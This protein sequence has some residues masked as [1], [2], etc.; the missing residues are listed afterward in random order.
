MV[1][2]WEITWTKFTLHFF[3]ECP[4]SSCLLP[5]QLFCTGSTLWERRPAETPASPASW[6]WLKANYTACHWGKWKNFHRRLLV[7]WNAEG[8]RARRSVING[9]AGGSLMRSPSNKRQSSPRM[10]GLTKTDHIRSR[11]WHQQNRKKKKATLLPLLPYWLVG[12]Q[13]ALQPCLVSRYIELVFKI[14]ANPTWWHVVGKRQQSFNFL[15]RY[16]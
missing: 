3:S 1:K 2:K 13:L 14:P 15:S 6:M 7:S 5:A 12:F 11:E 10:W 4:V 8:Q 9:C 16:H